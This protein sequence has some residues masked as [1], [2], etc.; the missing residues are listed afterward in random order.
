MERVLGHGAKCCGECELCRPVEQVEEQVD[1]AF[2]EESRVDP[3][4]PAYKERKKK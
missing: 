2:T 3:D 4:V 1:V